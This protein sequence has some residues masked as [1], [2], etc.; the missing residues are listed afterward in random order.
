MIYN[1]P[2]EMS[3]KKRVLHESPGFTETGWNYT[4]VHSACGFEKGSWVDWVDFQT[5]ETMSKPAF[6][7]GPGPFKIEAIRRIPIAP[8]A[9]IPER[10]SDFLFEISTSKGTAL[11]SAEQ[12]KKHIG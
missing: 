6:G 7:Y 2:N 4:E 12:F 8:G 9:E 1:K 3:D 11:M 5:A 10:M